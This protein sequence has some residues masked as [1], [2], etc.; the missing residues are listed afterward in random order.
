MPDIQLVLISVT[1]LQL[2]EGIKFA[3]AI[4]VQEI[5]AGLCR[6]GKRQFL[7]IV[8]LPQWPEASTLPLQWSKR[9]GKEQ[10][11]S[12]GLWQ[13]ALNMSCF[14]PYPTS[15]LV[16]YQ[17]IF[18]K[19]R[20]A[21]PANRSPTRNSP[22]TASG[23]GG[24]SGSRGIVTRLQPA[25]PRASCDTWSWW[26]LGEPWNCHQA[27]GSSTTSLFWHLVPSGTPGSSQPRLGHIP[28][29]VPCTAPRH[30]VTHIT[31]ICCISGSIR[32]AGSPKFVLQATQN[33]LCTESDNSA[34][35]NFDFS[36]VWEHTFPLSPL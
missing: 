29:H 17:S 14:L 2:T 24:S 18:R 9:R 26:Q 15:R 31:L 25:Q 11:T 20:N 12:R 28:P 22:S 16:L 32:F 30:P 5:Q 1:S 21:P 6:T 7:G 35:V 19:Q 36:R 13:P 8:L 34:E 3:T 23:A 33:S 4:T 10:R 27:S